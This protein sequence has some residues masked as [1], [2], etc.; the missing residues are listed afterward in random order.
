MSYQNVKKVQM[1]TASS[2]ST[3]KNTASE[4]VY[5]FTCTLCAKRN[6]TS[7]AVKFCLECQVYLCLGCTEWHNSFPS[8]AGHV[9]EKAELTSREKKLSLPYVPTERCPKHP[10][11]VIKMYCAKHDQVACTVCTTINHK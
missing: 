6:K 4:E 9:L 3:S 11:E 10:A 1:A 8:M 7:E 5:D 2:F